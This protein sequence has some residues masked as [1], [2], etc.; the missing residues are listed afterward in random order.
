MMIT[1]SLELAP[2]NG[3]VGPQHDR[4]YVRHTDPVYGS[5][6]MFVLRFFAGP[7]AHRISPSA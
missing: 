6:I 3:S 2:N 1:A 7:I 5:A 4:E